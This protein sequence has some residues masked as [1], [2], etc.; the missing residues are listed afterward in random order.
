MRK[1]LCADRRPRGPPTPPGR[2]ADRR[3]APA[4]LRYRPVRRPAVTEITG[5]GREW[6]AS[7]ISELSIP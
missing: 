5:R 7:M 4:V 3:A 2:P 6:T 1:L